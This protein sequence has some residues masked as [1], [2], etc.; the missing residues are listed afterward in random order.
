LHL[1][2]LALDGVYA[3][4]DVIRLAIFNI[5]PLSRGIGVQ[6]SAPFHIPTMF[7]FKSYV[8]A[9]GLMS[10][11]VDPSANF[12]QVRLYA[13]KMLNGAKMSQ[14]KPNDLLSLG[15][16]TASVGSRAY[17]GLDLDAARMPQ[18]DVS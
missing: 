14:Q 12:R 10:Y 2:V 16:W 4:E 7:I 18:G 6:N 5:D 8:Q 15:R 3:R 17:T 13:T 1:H 11:G 9:G